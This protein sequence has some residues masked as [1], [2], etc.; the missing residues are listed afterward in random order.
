[1]GRLG[2]LLW[3]V[4]AG[5]AA[6]AHA[7]YSFD[8]PEQYLADAAEWRPWHDVLERNALDSELLR[9]CVADL[10]HCPKRYRG[11][12]TLIIKGRELSLPDKLRL[13]NRY[14]NK[15]RYRDDRTS[16]PALMDGDVQK[17]QWRPLLETL[18]HGGDCE[19]FA[20]AKYFLL[21]ELGV[22]ANLMRVAVLYDREERAL[23]A[24]LAVDMDDQV[25]FLESDNTIQRG[26]QMSKYVYQY[27]MNEVGIWDHSM[28]ARQTDAHNS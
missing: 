18:S 13:A 16:R 8:N 11:V 19:D 17:N 6:A 7:D 25:W 27:S 15:R 23:H 3:G 2:A 1:M 24:M 28:P 9:V 20:T 21:R 26:W 4:L 22:P 14:V 10:T 12:A 5:L